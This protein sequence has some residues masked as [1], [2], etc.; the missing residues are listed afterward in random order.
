MKINSDGRPL[1]YQKIKL[2]AVKLLTTN[3]SRR[4]IAKHCHV[5]ATT[6]GRLKSRLSLLYL[7]DLVLILVFLR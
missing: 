2:I 5:S 6:V 7:K 4:A 1:S 3:E